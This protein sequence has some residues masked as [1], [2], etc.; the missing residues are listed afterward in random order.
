VI[1]RVFSFLGGIVM[2]KMAQNSIFRVTLGF[3]IILILSCQKPTTTD[4][5]KNVQTDK[6]NITQ[7][8][9]ETHVVS[10]TTQQP[11]SII[12]PA[13]G[14]HVCMRTLVSGSISDSSLQVF[15]LIHPMATGKF[16]IQPIPTVSSDGKWKAYCY[17]G[18]PNI[19]IGEPFEIVAVA[20]KNKKL[21]KEG[22]TLPSP[23]PDNPQILIRS[24]PITVIRAKCLN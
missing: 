10:Q 22:D 18:E 16:W 17:F 21:F 24:D 15:V 11:I 8:S 14:S 3:L 1:N 20:S 2:V 12:S 9:A 23:L 4:V 7:P 19:G 6:K 13:E 5:E